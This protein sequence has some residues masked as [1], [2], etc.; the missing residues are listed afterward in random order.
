MGLASSIYRINATMRSGVLSDLS[1][2]LSQTTIK[3]RLAIYIYLAI[4]L[5]VSISVV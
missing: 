2:N 5:F 3:P 4:R 1:S